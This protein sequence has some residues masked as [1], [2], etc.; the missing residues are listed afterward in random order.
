MPGTTEVTYHVHGSVDELARAMAEQ[1]LDVAQAAAATRGAARIAISGGTTPKRTFEMLADPAEKEFSLFPWDRLDLFWVDERCVPPDNAESNYRMTREALLDKVPLPE[2]RVFR[3]E[4]ELDPEEAAARYESSI[5]NRFRLEGAELPAFDLVA[6]GMGPD[7]HTASLFP[8]TE[9]LHELGR[10]AVANHVPQK[11][12]WRVTL[13][14]PVINEARKVVFLI[15]GADKAH[16]LSEVL[17]EK[18]DPETWPSQLVR[19][20]T[21]QLL[22]LLDGAASSELPAPG[23]SGRGHLEIQR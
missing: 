21:G 2:D 23:D 9:A 19:P 5:R 14:S 7:G 18:Y 10:I 6:L 16:V 3:I 12:S 22:L 17:S 13:T 11:D 20:R 8:H 1:I 15:S 4:G